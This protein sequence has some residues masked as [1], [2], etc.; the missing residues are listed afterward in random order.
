MKGQAAPCSA[1]ERAQARLR[2]ACASLCP[3]PR[4]EATPELLAPLVEWTG[5]ARGSILAL[6]PATGRLMIVAALGLPENLLGQEMAP[7]P[8]SISEWVF[9]NRRGLI[10]NGEVRD[11]R[12]EGSA[13]SDRIE[14]ALSL[15]LIA[16]DV[17][18]GVLN[19]ARVSP[20][21]AFAEAVLPALEPHLVPVAEALIRLLLTRGTLRAG[22]RL[23]S[24]S[25][26]SGSPLLPPGRSEPRC[27]ELALTH[28]AA[29]V[30]AGDLCERV[31]HA[32]GDQSLLVL[33]PPGLGGIAAATAAFLQGAFVTL[34]AP[35]RSAA[36][37]AARLSAEIHQRLGPERA[38]A[39]WVAQLTTR[40]D[41]SY[42]NAGHAW[43][44]WLP[45]DGGE[46]CRLGSG[47]PP[48]GALPAARYEEESLRLLPGDVVLIVSNG[49]LGARGPTD[50][51]FG[52][53]R[54]AELLVSLRAI[55]LERLIESV[56]DAAVEYSGRPV[57]TDD[58]TVLALRYR[59]EE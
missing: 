11:Q 12:F 3:E 20:A 51:P 5:A 46:V 25:T 16:A 29:A 57:P 49:L 36:G 55:P 24:C 15:P 37:M 33:D 53:E 35:E 17:P 13:A 39:A 52:S 32:G 18:I 31:A 54:L 19:L 42:C 43:P 47:G 56:L 30:P 6:N 38:T 41:L 50:Q 2:E 48:L 34:A 7:R 58:L 1:R 45:A 26:G 10:L 21:P 9:R 59:P 22:A 28:R 44:L 23:A 4:L 8:R 27:Y 40:G 14:S